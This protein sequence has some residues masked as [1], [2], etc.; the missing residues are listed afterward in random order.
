MSELTITASSSE[1]EATVTV[2]AIVVD[3]A[4]IEIDR[5][6][7]EGDDPQETAHA[8]VRDAVQAA[9]E[10]AYPG[11]PVE[12]AYDWEAN[13]R[14]RSSSYVRYDADGLSNALRGDLSLSSDELGREI[15]GLVSDAIGRCIQSGAWEGAPAL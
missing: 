12:V 8:A 9:V 3:L 13:N 14:Q 1:G 10:R 2:D 4:E 11:T 7:A 5:C 6:L 15:E